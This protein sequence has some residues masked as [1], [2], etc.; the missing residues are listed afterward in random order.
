MKRFKHLVIG[1]IE[2]KVFNLILITV[3]LMTGVYLAVSAYHSNALTKLANESSE[4][5]RASISQITDTIMD[6][7]VDKSM[8]R[9]TALQAYIVNDLFGG[10]KTRVQALEDYAQK[11]FSDPAAHPRA[12]YAAPDPKLNGQ[13]T[14]QLILA[15]GVSADDPALADKL[16][17]AANLSDLMVSLFGM[18]AETNSCFIALPDGA[19]LVTDDRS[20]TKFDDSGSLL[21]YDPRTRPWYQQA[22]EQKGLIFTDVETDAFTGDIG[23]V[24]A[25]PVYVDGQLAAVVGSDLFLTS[26]QAYVESSMENDSFIFI[27]NQNGHVVF[28]P[29]SEG[30]LQVLPKDQAADLRANDNAALA[31]FVRQALQERTSM[32]LIE[33]EDGGYYMIGAPMESVGWTLIS[34]CRCEAV[35]QPSEMLQQSFSQIQSE[36]SA[37][38]LE[39]TGRSRNTA[40]WLLIGIILVMLAAALIM[41]KRIVKPLNTITKRIS[42]LSESNLEFKMED[43]YRTGDE[44]QEL[45]ESF[46]AMS[47]KTVEYLD[48]VK[49]VTAEKERIGTELALATRIQADM[50]PNIYPAFPDRPEFDIYASMDPA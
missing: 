20:A 7:V 39:N 50:L 46:A 30:V 36:A 1:G 21:R 37:T 41:S 5:Q 13:V 17:L 8:S 11:L 15:D 45:A 2:T 10:L 23:I 33:L 32:Q 26:M 48:T 4:K 19:F 40:T 47:H 31:F 14:P 34:V 44:V 27:V 12:A 24:C 49:R 6:S 16:G 28:S 35:R 29:Q 42:E 9:T 22:V 25:M 18:S 43:T 3:L 38:Y